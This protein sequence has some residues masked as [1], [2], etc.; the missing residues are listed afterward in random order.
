MKRTI[1]LVL[2]LVLAISLLASCGGGG[3]NDGGGGG[4]DV[5]LSGKYVLAGMEIDG[6]DFFA[7]F[8]EAGVAPE[9]I[10]ILEFLSGGKCKMIMYDEEDEGTYAVSGKSVSITIDDDSIVGTIEGDRITLSQ[11]GD[12][13][14][15]GFSNMKLIFEKFSGASGG[16]GSGDSSGSADPVDSSGSGGGLSGKYLRTDG[17]DYFEFFADGTCVLYN[18]FVDFEM[19]GTYSVSGNTIT[20]GEG[21]EFDYDEKG[22]LDGDTLEWNDFVYEKE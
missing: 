10:Y 18:A 12:M 4:S 21:S 16:A 11:E 13:E 3:G 5:S 20:F 17:N 8:M 14:E 6:V 22:T 7:Q 15:D 9:D 19:D 2:V 1:K